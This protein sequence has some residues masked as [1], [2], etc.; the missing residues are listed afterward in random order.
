MFYSVISQCL[1][2]VFYSVISQCLNLVF[3]SVISQCLDLVF[4]S[5]ISQCLNLVFYSVISQCLDLVFYSVMAICSF[6][7]TR[8]LPFCVT[9]TTTIDGKSFVLGLFDTAGQVRL[10]LLGNFSL[11][12]S[13]ALVLNDSTA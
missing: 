8:V 7:H 1:N 9:A 12:A 10:K 3:Y 11:S 13:L 4:Y 5:L 6:F 2:L